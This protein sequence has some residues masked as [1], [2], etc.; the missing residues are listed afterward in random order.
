MSYTFQTRCRNRRRWPWGRSYPAPSPRRRFTP[1]S[2][3]RH[4]LRRN[5]KK[6][7]RLAGAR[8]PSPQSFG[9]RRDGHHGEARAS[10]RPKSVVFWG[11]PLSA[12]RCRKASSQ[13]KGPL[14]SSTVKRRA[15]WTSPV[16]SPGGGHRIR[17]FL[18]SDD[19][20]PGNPRH[21]GLPLRLCGHQQR[22]HVHS[23]SCLL[24]PVLRAK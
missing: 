1:G 12:A 2:E 22:E 11:P 9:L 3:E 4:A 10:P 18:M 24:L 17:L 7:C 21:H 19:E 6:S 5:V 23:S 8:P 15:T 16:H 13:G 14:G 20:G